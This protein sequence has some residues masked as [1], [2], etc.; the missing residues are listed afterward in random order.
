[1]VDTAASLH[2]EC[3]DDLNS[4]LGGPNG[5][6]TNGAGLFGPAES[7]GFGVG[8]GPGFPGAP[9]FVGSAPSGGFALP[10]ASPAPVT[11]TVNS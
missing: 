6:E 4:L 10:P 8:F 2:P 1:M 7:Y 9:G 11:S 5:T 3:A